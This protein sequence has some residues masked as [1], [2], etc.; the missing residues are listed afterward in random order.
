MDLMEEETAAISW[1]EENNLSKLQETV[2]NMVKERPENAVQIIK[3]WLLEI[4]VDLDNEA[5]TITEKKKSPNYTGRQKAAI[6]L[7]TIGTKI[8]AEIFKCLREDELDT[9]TFEIAKI[10]T[11]G[12]DRKDAVLQEFIELMTANRFVS[13]GGVDFAREVLEKS[14]GSQKTIDIL[15]RLISSLQ[16]PLFGFIRSADPASLFNI[17]ML[18]HPQTI[19]VVLT[20]LEPQKASLILK[21]LP[22]DLQSEVARRIAIMDKPSLGALREIE[23]VLERKLSTHSDEYYLAT[24]GVESIVEILNM[25]GRASEKKIIETLE[26]EDPE[27][28]EEI[29]KMMFVFEDIV[30]LDDYSIQRVMREVDSQEL[31]KA[32]KSEDTVVQEKIFRNMSKRAADILREDMENMGSIGLNDVEESQQNIVS[33]I[34]HLENT[35]EIVIARA[36]EGELVVGKPSKSKFSWNNIFSKLS[37]N[38]KNL[39]LKSVKYKTLVTALKLPHRDVF[40]E[41]TEPMGFFKRIKLK[42][43]IYILKDFSANDVVDAQDK[44]KAI[45]KKLILSETTKKLADDMEIRND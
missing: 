17:I 33:I 6:F 36:G 35:G 21:N 30:R 43:D 37:Y 1:A 8:S 18:E 13:I 5:D 24:G 12:P 27:L 26:D 3:T 19:A 4:D 22:Y 42:L 14:L 7:I 15:N 41:L 45:A 39:L 25:V 28:V 16:I 32:L 31:A 10:E 20:Y 11:I 2:T 44:I 9:L 23:R 34:R 40:R 38:E 29:K